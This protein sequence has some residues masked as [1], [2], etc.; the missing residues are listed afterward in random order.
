MLQCLAMSTFMLV[1]GAWHGA[2]CW[3]KVLPR[4]KKLGHDVLAPDLPGLGLDNTPLA[5]VTLPMWREHLCHML[6]EQPGPV[7]LVGHSRAGVVISEVAEH[8][9]DKVALLVYLAAF[10]VPSGRCLFDLAQQ[11][12]ESVLSQ[13]MKISPDKTF[14]TVRPS[15][16][17]EAFYGDCADEDFEFARAHL[18]PEPLVAFT[19]AL[20][21]SEQNFGRVPRVYIECLRDRA[22]PPALQ[23]SMHAALPCREIVQLDADHSPFFSRPDE[24]TE[25]LHRL[26]QLA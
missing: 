17:R 15:A 1:H 22:V 23:R 7:V 12:T 6:D 13:H 5:Q 11:D 8:R 24:L 14:A 4:L 26:A 25:H 10:L 19:T 9:P 3:R 21:L 16:L 2:W 20:S 18:K